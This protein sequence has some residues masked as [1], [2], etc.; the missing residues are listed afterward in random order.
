MKTKDTYTVNCSLIDKQ[1]LMGFPSASIYNAWE[2]HSAEIQYILDN[3]L[4]EELEIYLGI[5]KL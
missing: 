1:F 3:H 5:S 2:G 4:D